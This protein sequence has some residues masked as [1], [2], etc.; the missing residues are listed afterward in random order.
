MVI[1][2]IIIIIIIIINSERSPFVA[3]PLRFSVPGLVL[4]DLW[5]SPGGSNTAMNIIAVLL[6]LLLLLLLALLLVLLLLLLLLLFLL[7]LIIIIN[8]IIIIIIRGRRPGDEGFVSLLAPLLALWRF[9]LTH[10]RIIM[11][12]KQYI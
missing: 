3:A 9:E 2:A 1:I 7:H 11:S 10:L 12:I 6:L 4:L 5:A 8:I